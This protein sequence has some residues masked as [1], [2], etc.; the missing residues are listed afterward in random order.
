MLVYSITQQAICT[1]ELW[2]LIL[3]ISCFTQ[4]TLGQIRLL[5]PFYPLLTVSYLPGTVCSV[6]QL[7]SLCCGI[8]VNF[9]PTNIQI[10][11]TFQFEAKV[12]LIYRLRVRN[13]T[14]CK[15]RN[16]H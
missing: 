16:E 15:K 3:K 5:H 11:N 10:G 14:N 8:L 12:R 13:D 1:A 9:P 7:F 2:H 4:A 6:S